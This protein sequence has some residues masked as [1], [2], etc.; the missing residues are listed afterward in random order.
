MTTYVLVPGFWLG[1][2]AWDEVAA[3]LRARG[4]DV[5]AVELRGAT[6]EE[7]VVQV[8]E[9]LR[10]LDDVVLV[11]HS[12]GG[13]VITAAADRV[14]ERVARL[15]YVDTGPLPD[16]R[17]QA[18]FDGSPPQAVDGL[19]PVSEAA[20]PVVHER[21]R[22]QPVATAT[23]PVHHTGAW[24]ALPRTAILCSF[25]EAQLRGMA[26]TVP[27]FALM[28]GDGWTFAELKSDHWPMFS[29]PVALAALIGSGDA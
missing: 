11:G 27:L 4:H 2:W 6:V 29:A 21:G 8:T 12:Y 15:V 5:H 7:H 1:A 24:R 20:P 14:P 16:G 3:P 25:S 17:A 22:P 13:L 26:A 19:V 28:A 18:D 9:L 10:E 23:D